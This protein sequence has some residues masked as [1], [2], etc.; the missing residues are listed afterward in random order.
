MRS[1]PE[2]YSDADRRYGAAMEE[3]FIPTHDNTAVAPRWAFGVIALSMI[4]YLCCVP[5]AITHLDFAR[6]LGIALEIA[7]GQNWPLS[8]PPLNGTL[9]L[10]PMWYYLLAIPL[11]ITHS[12]IAVAMTIGVIAA[13]KFPLAYA[14]GSRLVDPAFGLLWAVMLGLPGWNSFE[15]LL[16]EHTSLVATCVLGF[17]W[18]L[19]RYHETGAARF[20]HGLSL[21]YA[22]ALHAHPSTLALMLVGAPVIWRSWSGTSGRWRELFIA[23]F[24]FL[25]PFLP[26]VAAQIATGSADLRAAANY[27]SDTGGLGRISDI[28]STARGVLA[29]GP[30][31]IRGSVLQ[32]DGAWAGAFTIFYVLVWAVVIAGLASSL[33]ARL[34]RRAA[35]FGIAI[36]LVIGVSVVLIRAYTPYYMSYVI[37]TLLLGLA[38]FGLRAAIAVRG[39]R[40]PAWLAIVGVSTL[41][42]VVSAGVARTFSSGSYPFAVAPLFDIKQPYAQGAALPFVPAYAMAAIGDALCAD[43]ALVAHGVLGFHLLHDYALETKLR[44]AAPPG[45]LIGGKEPADMPHLTGLSRGML[46]D[47]QVDATQSARILEAGPLSLFPVTQVLNPVNGES[48]A[49]PGTFPPATFTFG[50]PKPRVLQFAAR[51]DEM[52]IVTNMY[53]GAFAADPTVLASVNGKAVQ[54]AAADALSA[55]YVCQD[56]APDAQAAWT[57]QLASPAPDRVD[58]V[59][60][61]P[62]KH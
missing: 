14:L 20:L 54:P 29:T 24:M 49:K 2:L 28:P 5:F 61:I 48:L 23:A 6:D 9:H 43:R 8:G 27:F 41:P 44:C 47:L 10:G 38:A 58:V 25:L 15:V 21:M 37:L 26:F 57:L 45:V 51:C 31:V 18:M 12:W 60:V 40:Y 39:I 36:V 42:I 30:Q 1:G 53:H 19:L 7:N 33:A 32:L 34:A 35:M 22:L 52:V 4:T 46:R 50:A 17:L 16:I 55:A 13:L 3:R 59:T 56:G 62:N 11:A